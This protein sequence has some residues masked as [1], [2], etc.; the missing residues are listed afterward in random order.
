M[1]YK[2]HVNYSDY[3]IGKKSPCTYQCI[4]CEITVLCIPVTIPVDR[5]KLKMDPE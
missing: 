3:K 4:A 5:P 2:Y 1:K